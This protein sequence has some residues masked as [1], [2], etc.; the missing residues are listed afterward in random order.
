MDQ[1]RLLAKTLRWYRGKRVLVTGS[2]GYLGSKVVRLL[3]G[4]P[5]EIDCADLSPERPADIASA[6]SLHFHRLDIR[7]K[8]ALAKLASKADIIFH[9]AAQTSAHEADA[10][11]AADFQLNVQPLFNMLEACRAGANRPIIVFASTVTAF[12]VNP[13][14]PVNERRPDQPVTMYDV[15]KIAAEKYL[16]HYC[17]MDFV[18]GA[19]LRLANVYGPGSGGVK[20]DRG[21]FN[22]MVQR[23]LGGEPLTVYG[24]G[25]FLRDYVYVDDVVRA[26]LLV[27]P[28]IK[29]VN[30][31]AF[32]IGTGKAHTIKSVFLEIASRAGKA[33]GRLVKTAYKGAD[34]AL[35]PA[36]RRNF[37]ADPAAFIKA[38]GWKPEF[39]L[40][41]GLEATIG[42]F[43]T[44]RDADGRK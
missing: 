7:K 11:P 17:E 36:D 29:S 2:S 33:A 10:D 5:C 3:A 6:A 31:R 41:Q 26:F 18:R 42:S 24:S 20:K 4:V 39:S 13:R 28:N 44:G 23:A 30:G 15:H 12:G 27:P 19:A 1:Q 38:T 40:R 14:L 21:I 16:F 37:R 25:N 22:R 43:L 35:H 8:P 32:V 9:F 34:S